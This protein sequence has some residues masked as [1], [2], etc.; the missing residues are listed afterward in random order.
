MDMRADNAA[1]DTTDDGADGR[2]MGYGELAEIRGID[3]TSA[4][5][6]S[7]RRK[8]RKQKTND[9]QVRVLVPLDWIVTKDSAT[10]SGAAD[11]AIFAAAVASLTARSE[12]AEAEADRTIAAAE[13]QVAAV[14]AHV[15][16][17]A[18]ALRQAE[19][20]LA[21]ATERERERRR[22]GRWARLRAA[23]RG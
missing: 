5:K 1:D 2:W 19:S 21:E 7:L 8:W 13:A 15:D 20:R 14:Q 12:R 18:E 9:G 11:K 16:T 17:L 4:L 22:L 3:R 6:L 10:A 23:W